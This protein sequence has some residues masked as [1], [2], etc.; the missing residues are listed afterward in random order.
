MRYCCSFL[1][2]IGRVL[3]SVVF[4]L[5]GIQKIMN[6]DAAAQ[7]MSAS[8]LN[9][10]TILLL[11]G[12]I[13][14]EILGGLSVLFGYKTRIGAAVLLF[15]LIAVTFTMHR[16]WEAAPAEAEM[17][18]A[19]FLKN[20]AIMGGLLYVISYGCGGCSLDS[21]CR[22]T[23]RREDAVVKEAPLPPADKPVT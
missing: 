13:A 15:F 12:A 1:A 7:Y 2:L 8:G 4:I 22:K 18:M 16:F 17:Q 3:I 9:Q 11:A 5:S 6:W 19:M 23:C 14:I 21:I 10:Y 20:L